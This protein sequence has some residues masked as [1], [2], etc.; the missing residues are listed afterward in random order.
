MLV[1]MSIHTCG[2]GENLLVHI[3]LT[4]MGITLL[5]SLEI[6]VVVKPV[7]EGSGPVFP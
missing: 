4:Y 1:G 6:P 7:Q 3:L 2:S 5:E